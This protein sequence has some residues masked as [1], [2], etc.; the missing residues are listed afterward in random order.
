MF[1]GRRGARRG[2]SR[3]AAPAT[4]SLCSQPAQ[5]STPPEQAAEQAGC[6]SS[7]NILNNINWWAKLAL[8]PDEQNY[9][10]VVACCD[11]VLRCTVTETGTSII[12]YKTLP[13]ES[14]IPMYNSRALN[15]EKDMYFEPA[16]NRFVLRKDRYIMKK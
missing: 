4:A 2:T 8:F 5:R 11:S 15:I 3:V 9:L 14:V 7:V 13:H 1:T 10:R 6:D 16:V 12:I